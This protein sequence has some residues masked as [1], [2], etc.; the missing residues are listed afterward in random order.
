[1]YA[2]LR[3]DMLR[4]TARDTTAVAYWKYGRAAECTGLENQRWET[5]RGFKSLYFR[6]PPPVNRTMTAVRRGFFVAAIRHY[7]A[8]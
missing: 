8:G 6:H 7:S 2:F 5:I 3:T 1:M 4:D